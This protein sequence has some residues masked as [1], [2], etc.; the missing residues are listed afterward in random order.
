[1]PTKPRGDRPWGDPVPDPRTEER[2]L[3]DLG[4]L[5]RGEP[6]ASKALGDNVVLGPGLWAAL[7]EAD[8]SFATVGAS[9]TMLVPAPGGGRREFQGRT[10]LS[11]EVE[12]LRT[13]EVFQRMAADFAKGRARPATGAERRLFYAMIPFEIAG[14]PLTMVDL[15]TARLAVSL[16][17]GRIDWLDLLSAY[18]SH[19]VESEHRPPSTPEQ[20]A[21]AV[22]VARRLERDP[23]MDG[24]PLD[25]EVQEAWKWLSE[26]PDVTAIVCAD[27]YAEVMEK[28]VAF[29]VAI[30]AMLGTAAFVIESP[31]D[32]EDPV[33]ASVAGLRSVLRAYASARPKGL[34]ASAALDEFTKLDRAGKLGAHVRE[35]V[36]SCFE[37]SQ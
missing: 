10:F 12:A 3:K 33:N 21:H 27:L 20:K 32:A 22:A 6:A 26:A 29:N 15:G 16:T 7:T 37:Q 13:A 14:Q 28:P 17:E 24:V 9:S 11:G 31:E 5:G 8:R 25:T 18:A 1:M 35:R 2:I 19:A 4:A 36:R 30:V 34:S 23:P